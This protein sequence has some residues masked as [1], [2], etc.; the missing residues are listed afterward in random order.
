ME[1]GERPEHEQYW[2]KAI[3]SYR[4]IVGAEAALGGR[5]LGGTARYALWHA[6][7]SD[8]WWSDF[9]SGYMID[10]WLRRVREEVANSMSGV[11]ASLEREVIETLANRET[12]VGI[13]ISNETGGAGSA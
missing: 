2:I 8:F 4:S 12:S 5:R 9:W 6:V 1:G 7:D 13:R 3:D 11:R 10:E